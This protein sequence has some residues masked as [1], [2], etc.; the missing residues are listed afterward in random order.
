MTLQL[1][2]SALLSIVTL[3]IFAND[4]VLKEIQKCHIASLWL[5][6]LNLSS[7]TLRH[8]DRFALKTDF[9]ETARANR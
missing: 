6:V 4:Q 5:D 1:Q 7:S 8:A 3:L 9:N 2:L